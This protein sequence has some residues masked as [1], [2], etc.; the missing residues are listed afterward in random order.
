MKRLLDYWF[1]AIVVFLLAGAV[2]YSYSTWP[3][4]PFLNFS[5]SHSTWPPDPSLDFSCGNQVEPEVDL[6]I[7][8]PPSLPQSPPPEW[9]V[10]D[11]SR[12]TCADYLHSA[13]RIRGGGSGGSGACFKIDDQYVYVLTCQH[14][15]GKTKDFKVEFWSDGRITGEYA[16]QASKWITIP[17]VDAAVILI[18]VKDFKEDELPTA[19]P[20]ST[21]GPDKNEPIVSVGC[22]GLA[23]Q[24]L[25]EG[26]ITKMNEKSKQ[27]FKFVPPPKGGRSG[28]AIFQDGKIVGVL[29]GATDKNGYAVNCMDLKNLTEPTNLFF[30]AN[31]CQ[32]CE[33]MQPVLEMLKKDG[34]RVQAIDY[35]LNTAFAELYGIDSL[36]AYVNTK[37]ETISGVKTAEELRKFY[38]NPE[39]PNGHTYFYDLNTGKK[40][41]YEVTPLPD[42][43]PE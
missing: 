22:A 37:G 32:Y 40:K 2:F 17:N 7:I 14:V 38:G 36:P 33:E 6:E 23:W 11:P 34:I 21:S 39:I 9:S 28:S 16:G 42:G 24:T 18:P 29:W 43:G 30:T 27:S 19:I 26:H 13:C 12:A 15:V 25:F 3:P 4:D 20:I 8:I 31:W 41:E 10:V 5:Y 1:H 35:D